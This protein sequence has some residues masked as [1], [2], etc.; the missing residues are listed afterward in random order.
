M[1]ISCQGCSLEDF[2]DYEKNFDEV[3]LNFL[4]KFDDGNIPNE[5]QIKDSLKCN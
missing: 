5:E 4:T 3:Y 2:L 1:L